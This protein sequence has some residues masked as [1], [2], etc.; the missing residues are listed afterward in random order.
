MVDAEEEER[1]RVSGET[2]RE[3]EAE[4]EEVVV[5]ECE[6]EESGA[7]GSVSEGAAWEAPEPMRSRF[8]DARAPRAR[9][10]AG[11]EVRGGVGEETRGLESMLMGEEGWSMVVQVDE[12]GV[13]SYVRRSVEIS[14]RTPTSYSRLASEPRIGS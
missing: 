14:Y 8:S 1:E 7:G 2:V 6:K 4:E 3:M 10:G 11:V 5:R 13:E 9:V 12:F